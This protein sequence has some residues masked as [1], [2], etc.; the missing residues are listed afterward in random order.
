MAS[1]SA[2][3]RFNLL[4]PTWRAVAF[5]VAASACL[6]CMHG[7]VRMVSFGLHPFEIAFFRNLFGLM[8]YLPWLIRGGLI[9]L[10]TKR[11]GAHVIRG[12]FN[13]GSMLLWFT[14]L[15]MVPLAEATA[16]SLTGPLF[17]TL[18]AMA[19]L[20]EKVGMGRWL[21]VLIGGSGALVIIRP[22]F[23]ALNVGM[24]LAVGGTCLVA[25]SKLVAKS[26]TRTESAATVAFYV[27]LNMGIITGCFAIFVWQWPT[28]D[29]LLWLALIGALG[30]VGHFLFTKAYVIAD[31]S[32]AE[33]IV[34]TRLI[35]AALFGFL[36]FTEVPDLFTWI[37]AALIVGATSYNASREKAEKGKNPA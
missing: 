21:A 31:V 19:F 8:V 22:G 5:M 15:S 14:S 6:A 10:H 25:V 24:L 23:E 18:G 16:L 9:V 26:L 35:W 33:P 28:W 4:S 17:V 13:S 32:F 29:Q 20:G 7:T 30:G 11:P 36:V 37:G 12:V 34:F 27:Q 3:E 2:A 1:P